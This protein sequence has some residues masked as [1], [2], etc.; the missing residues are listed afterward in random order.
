[1]ATA[2]L[3]SPLILVVG[4]LDM[5]GNALFILAAQAGRLDVAAVLSSLYPVV[6][7]FLAG[8]CSRNASPGSTR[9]AS[10]WR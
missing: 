2:A 4:C 6:T 7:L 5:A 3:G 8:S 10:R 9:S 1:M